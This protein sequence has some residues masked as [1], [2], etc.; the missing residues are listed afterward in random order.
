MDPLDLINRLGRE[1]E[2]L[3]KQEFLAPY[4]TG[5]GR[6]RVRVQGLVYQ[7]RTAPRPTCGVGIFRP[8]SIKQA[9][10]VREAR[11]DQ[12]EAYLGQFPIVR[13]MTVFKDG[14]WWAMPPLVAVIELD[15]FA[16]D[17]IA[18][19]FEFIEGAFDGARIW[20]K[21]F[22]PKADVVKQDALR[23]CQ[24]LDEAMRVKGLT[25]QDRAAVSLAFQKKE[26]QRRLTLEGRV[27]VI[28][29][30]RRAMLESIREFSD[31]RVEVVWKSRAGA[32]YRSVIKADDLSVVSAG[33][34]LSG[35]DRHFD[36]SSL[37]GVVH[38]GEDDDVIVP[39]E[40]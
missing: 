23:R 25:P 6:V 26:E 39:G 37:I 11:P 13:A 4:F 31:G 15:E 1:E 22:D 27:Q 40:F 38:E 21:N 35:E 14:F 34:C 8:S 10:F 5:Y 32:T 28:L 24:S 2:N 20:M 33:I 12:I 9:E 16:R 17:R 3:R 30:S 7:F 18:G 19:V 29:K 36:L